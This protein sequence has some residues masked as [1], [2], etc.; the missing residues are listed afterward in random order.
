[1]VFVAMSMV[2]TEVKF[3]VSLLT[4]IMGVHGS[5][6]DGHV[7]SGASG[8]MLPSILREDNTG[9]IFM[10]KNTVI[11]SRTKHVDVQYRFVNN[12]VLAEELSEEHI[13]S[14]ENPSDCMTKN[15][16]L[17][18]FGKHAAL[19]CDGRL[20]RLHEPTNTEDVR[21]NCATVGKIDGLTVQCD[22]NVGGDGATV[23]RNTTASTKA[24]CSIGSCSSYVLDD[25]DLGCTVVNRGSNKSKT[26]T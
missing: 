19:I 12:M 21:S 3:I 24:I 1:M 5:S 7:G 26:K 10:A 11:G 14:G 23:P 17:A 8:P 22:D 15:L 20:A 9:A 4:E 16:P 18:V 2:A 25:D 6:H 13:R